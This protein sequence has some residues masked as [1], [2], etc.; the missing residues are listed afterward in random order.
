MTA[1]WGFREAVAPVAPKAPTRASGGTRDL[2]RAAFH[3][4]MR[5]ACYPAMSPHISVDAR[6]KMRK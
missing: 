4:F 3:V 5:V 6:G 1:A 2:V